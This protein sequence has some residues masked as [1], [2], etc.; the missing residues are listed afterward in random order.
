MAPASA[1][2]AGDDGPGPGPSSYRSSSVGP[3]RRAPDCAGRSASCPQ[4]RK[5][6]RSCNRRPGCTHRRRGRRDCTAINIRWLPAD[7]PV[8]IHDGKAA[9]LRSWEQE[10]VAAAAQRSRIGFPGRERMRVRHTRRS[11]QERSY[12]QVTGAQTADGSSTSLVCKSASIELPQAVVR[13]CNPQS[14]RARRTSLGLGSRPA[15]IGIR[16]SVDLILRGDDLCV[17]TVSREARG[18]RCLA[19]SR[20]SRTEC[21]KQPAK[22]KRRASRSADSSVATDRAARGYT[23]C[24]VVAER[25]AAADQGEAR[26]EIRLGP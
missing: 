18:L 7:P 15:A 2:P 5:C 24:S 16:H 11:P 12:R 10:E 21:W 9:P 6:G 1:S 8:S 25:T 26:R 13:R 14:C 3:S 17:H 20:A 4:K 23:T 19:R 22:T